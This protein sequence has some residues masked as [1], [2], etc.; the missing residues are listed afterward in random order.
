MQK[1]SA[2]GHSRVKFAEKKLIYSKVHG[3]K[4][5]KK[6]LAFQKF[7]VVL[8]NKT[9]LPTAIASFAEIAKFMAFL[10]LTRVE[11]SPKRLRRQLQN[12][13]FWSGKLSIQPTKFVFFLKR[14]C[15]LFMCR[16]ASLILFKPQSQCH[17]EHDY[18]LKNER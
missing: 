15:S 6:T 2:E 7:S 18:L 13:L 11:L 12:W 5:M 9:F 14:F 16:I 3:H 8:R 17:S 10:H 4:N 1:S